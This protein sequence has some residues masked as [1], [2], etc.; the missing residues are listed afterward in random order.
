MRYFS[1]AML[2]ASAALCLN[3]SAYS[4][5][6]SLKINN[7]TV[8]EAM[9]R[10]KKDTGYSFVFSS[11]DVNTSKRISVSVSDASIEEVI[12]QI[13]KGQQGLDYEIQGKKIVLRKAQPVSINGNQEK[14]TVSGKVVDA[15]GEPVIGAT[16]MEKGTTNGTITDFDGNFN[17]NVADGAQLDISYIGYKTQSIK[18]VYGKNLAITLGEDTEMLDEVVVVGYGSMRKSDLTGAVNRANI[19]AFEDSPNISF[20]QSLQGAL[21]GVNVGATT[22]AGGEPSL[23]IRGQNTFSGSTAPLIVLD[24]VIYRGN[25]ID[26]N[27]NDIESID[28]LKDASSKAIYG[29]QAANG[30]ILITTK[31]GRKNKKPEFNVS[32]FYS[33]SEPANYVTPLNRDEYIAKIS[34][35]HWEEA[36]TGPDYLTPVDNFDPTQ[37]W[38][39]E[40]IKEGYKLGTNTNWY[41]LVTQNPF[42]YNINASMSG[43][44]DNLS[45]YLSAG[46]VDE[47]GF[48]RNDNY[49]KINIR[50]NFDNKITNWLKIGMQTFLSTGDYSGVACNIRNGIIYSPLVSPYNEDGTLDLY[51][52]NNDMNPLTSLDI[53]DSDKRLNL[54]GN[55]YAEVQFPFIKGL[56]YKINYSTNYRT[57]NQYQFN[58][59]GLNQSG[60]AYKNHSVYSDETLDN[61]VNYA[62]TFDDI[63]SVN[64]TFVYGYEGRNGESTGASSGDYVNP[65]LGYHNLEGGNLEQ[66]RVSSGAWEEYSLYQMLRLN[67]SLKNTYMGTFTIRRDGFSGFGA[68]HKFGIFPSGALAWVASNEKFF[69]NAMPWFNYLKIRASYGASGNRTAGRY[70]TLAR[71]S[72]GYRY[73]FGDGGKPTYG[74][75]ISSLP[76]T[77]LGW[78]TTLGWNLGF[79]FGFLDNRISGTIEYYRSNTHDILFNVNLPYMTGFGSVTSNIGKV[80]NKGLEITLNTLN[81]KTN[82]FEWRTTLNFARNRNKVVSILGQDADGDGREDDLIANKLFIGEPLGVIYDYVI[83]GIYQIGDDIPE[84]YHPG[85]Y[86]I[87][88]TDNSGDITPDD[89]QILGYTSPAYTVSMLNELR[90]KNWALTFF[91]N[92]IQGGKD[93]YRGSNSPAGSE[94]GWRYHEIEQFNTIKEFDYWTPS[95]PNAEYAGLRYNEP[96]MP[97]VYK[98]RSFVRLQDVSL[99][100]NFPK[101]WLQWAAI[102]GLKLYFS[103]KNLFTI[104]GWKGVDPETGAGLTSGSYPVMRSYTFGL[105]LTF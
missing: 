30:V 52:F 34:D 3:L 62:R 51:P 53:D 76:N 21:P 11:K 82:D 85:N 81:V 27:N 36:F 6:I 47:A 80:S 44:T 93:Y 59:Y 49:N 100:Y 31:N 26:I 103:G 84:G 86:I 50:A 66:Q 7:V 83:E 20:V 97:G 65:T 43:A 105:N 1:K 68:D 17:L 12:K 42:I 54:F 18:A 61:I 5:D 96:I 102:K 29:S 101:E 73:V 91:I 8:K 60:S 72:D 89:R 71:V 25:L 69:Q 45:Y 40:K 35:I 23:S 13:L 94:A 70:S 4:Q 38:Q 10:V 32:A 39:A 79:D 57:Y 37:F 64:A 75:N 63:H 22:G 90:Y 24:G 19:E 16:I 48:A 46:Y 9:E 15:K 33:M 95:N 2:V 78:E 77:E 41:D 14:R 87:K 88:D 98:N 92:S 55:F 56:S 74:Q 99:S 67:Y 28:V 58:P 104:T